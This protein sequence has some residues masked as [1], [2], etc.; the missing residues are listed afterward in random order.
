MYASD[1]IVKPIDQ[2]RVKTTFRRIQQMLKMSEKKNSTSHPQAS[3]ISINLGNE[4]VFVKLSDIFYIEKSGRYTF[5]CCVN[6]K[7]KT[8]QTL[9]EL[10]QHL[11]P[12][13]FRF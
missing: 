7:F 8:R 11:G 9:Q 2:E 5:I 6:G 10:E 3:R 1:Y 4:W 12:G 13:F